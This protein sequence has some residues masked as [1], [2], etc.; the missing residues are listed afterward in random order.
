MQDTEM[1]HHCQSLKSV[2]D[3]NIL[4]AV[5]PGEDS[6]TIDRDTRIE[7]YINRAMAGG[8]GPKT[9]DMVLREVFASTDRDADE[10]LIKIEELEDK[11]DLFT[12]L[13]GKLLDKDFGEHTSANDPWTNALEALQDT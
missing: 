1:C 4:Y 10:L 2:G 3:D 6:T 8:L 9:L 7:K 12:E 5:Q 11:L 13:V